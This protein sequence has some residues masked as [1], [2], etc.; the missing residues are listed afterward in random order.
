MWISRRMIASME[1]TPVTTGSR[2]WL[3]N[4]KDF[5]VK[6]FPRETRL[7]PQ[8]EASSALEPLY[9]RSFIGSPRNWCRISRYTT[10][11]SNMMK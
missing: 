5:A 4:D 3:R 6:T 11:A 9:F 1:Y 7:N 8:S 10:G 2:T